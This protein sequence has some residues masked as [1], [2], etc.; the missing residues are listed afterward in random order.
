MVE[1]EGCKKA[2]PLRIAAW[3]VWVCWEGKYC[4]MI[5]LWAFRFDFKHFLTDLLH[6]C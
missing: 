5:G 6:E 1:V 4:M 3:Q 2:R